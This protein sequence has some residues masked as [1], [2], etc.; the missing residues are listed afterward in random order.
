MS[1]V[2]SCLTGKN[3]TEVDLQ[4]PR[5]RPF[6]NIQ[7][8]PP[9]DLRLENTSMP[10][11]N[12][13]WKLCAVSYYLEQWLEYQL[14]YKRKAAR[15]DPLILSIGQDQKW[16]RLEELPPDTEFEAAVRVK[17]Q[18]ESNYNSVWSKW[19]KPI[20]W[21]TYSKD[22]VALWNPHILLP[23]L[24]VGSFLTIFLIGVTLMA[25][26]QM[27]KWLRKLLKI[28]LPDPS[29]FLPS[30]TAVHGD[31]QKWL[32]SPLFMSSFHITAASPDV[33]T[34]EIIQKGDQE[35]YFLLSKE[36]LSSMDTAETSGHSSSSC[37]TNRGYFFFHNVDS[38][39]IEPCKVYFTYDPFAQDGSGSEDGDSCP[40]KALHAADN[41]LPLP[42]YG[43]MGHE[44]VTS[45]LPERMEAI[46]KAGVCS[47][48]LPSVESFPKSSTEEQNE[49]QEGS[50]AIVQSPEPPHQSV[51]ILSGVPEQAISN[52]KTEAI[53]NTASHTNSM[54]DNRSPFLQPATMNQGQLNDLCR[55]VSLSQIV[56]DEAYVSLRDFQSHRIHH[57]V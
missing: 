16:L 39:E 37:F 57:S 6:Q 21:R 34:L 28:H 50:E 17:T 20:T 26:S 13:T 25:K 41:N 32:S 47:K 10:S 40:Y 19:S 55:T 46:Q 5:F 3:V 2:V 30:L 11:Y 14:Q 23:V 48:V 49:D 42:S 56:S 43:I 38:L 45:F 9:C 53:G 51:V 33:S 8:K 22:Q 35:P 44:S 36:Y 27:S 15:E 1:L 52:G 54:E 29:S 24:T 18:D 4:V 7:L 31:I 12:L